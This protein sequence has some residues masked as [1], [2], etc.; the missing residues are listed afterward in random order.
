MY[1]LIFLS[2]ETHT[3]SLSLQTQTIDTRQTLH[4]K[5]RWFLSS[6]SPS[7]D[8]GGS[9]DRYNEDIRHQRAVLQTIINEL[10]LYGRYTWPNKLKRVQSSRTKSKTII[11]SLTPHPNSFVHV[12]LEF[13]IVPTSS[14]RGSSASFAKGW[15]GGNLF[16][17]PPGGFYRKTFSSPSYPV[18]NPLV[19]VKDR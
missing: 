5:Q 16:T 15:H 8:Y 7:S 4:A 3:F 19:K 13:A 14:R 11:P 17:R 6:S 2:L 18:W 10:S 12:V 9:N 1:I